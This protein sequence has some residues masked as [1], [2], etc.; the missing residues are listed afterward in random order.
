MYM[1]QEEGEIMIDKVYTTSI[2][3]AEERSAGRR[4]GGKSL[5]SFVSLVLSPIDV[6]SCDPESGS[7][8][9]IPTFATEQCPQGCPAPPAIMSS[10]KNRPLNDM[11]NNKQ[12]SFISP[13]TARPLPHGPI[14]SLNHDDSVRA[15]VVTR[16]RPDSHD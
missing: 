13:P 5:L 6:D 1:N 8:H 11:C 9:A 4:E 12:V 16:L 14:W 3:A 7:K 2:Y 10:A 15:H